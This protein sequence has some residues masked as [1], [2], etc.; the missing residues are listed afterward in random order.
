MGSNL[1]KLAKLF[2]DVSSFRCYDV[3]STLMCHDT[4]LKKWKAFAV[5]LFFDG[6]S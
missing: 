2:D 1:F 6:L 3:I 5:S 4:S